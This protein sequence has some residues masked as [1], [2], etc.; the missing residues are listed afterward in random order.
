MKHQQQQCANKPRQL[1]ATEGMRAF[2]DKPLVL[3]IGQSNYVRSSPLPC[4]VR[5]VELFSAYWRDI[6]AL[7]HTA[8]DQ[9]NK[10]IRALVGRVQRHLQVHVNIHSMVSNSTW[11]RTETAD[12]C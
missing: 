10:E 5:D 9:T 7:V 1:G 8:F 12:G 6:G 3:C 2:Q 4:T 11:Q